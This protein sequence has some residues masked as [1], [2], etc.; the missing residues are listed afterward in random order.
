[1]AEKRLDIQGL[2]AILLAAVMLFHVWPKIFT[3]C[4]V[5]IDLYV[6]FIVPSITYGVG[7]RGWGRIPLLFWSKIVKG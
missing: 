4:F 6:F 7:E 1:M 3:G 5:A 2:R